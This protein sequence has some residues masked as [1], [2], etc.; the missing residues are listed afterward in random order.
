MSVIDQI[1]FPFERG[2]HCALGELKAFEATLSQRRNECKEAPRQVRRRSVRPVVPCKRYS[3]GG[4]SAQQPR[5]L[6][7]PGEAKTIQP[8]LQSEATLAHRRQKRR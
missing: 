6:L 8:I 3:L 7:H 1:T 2:R 5:V 4:R